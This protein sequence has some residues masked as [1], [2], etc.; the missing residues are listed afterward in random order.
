MTV[1]ASVVAG[2]L[3]WADAT[4]AQPCIHFEGRT[5]TYNDVR[6]TAVHWAAAFAA[7]GITPGERVALFLDNCPDFLAAYLGISLAG[8]VVVLVN[9]Q[10][11]QVELR[12][13]LADSGTRL[14]ITDAA[15]HAELDRVRADLPDLTGI[16][17]AEEANAFLAA[18]DPAFTP[19]LPAGDDLAVLGYT[20]GTTGRAKGAMILHRNLA[21]NSA[22]IREAWEWTA[23]DH[24]LLT[25]PLFHTHGL[26]VGAHGTLTAGATMSLSRRFDA[27]AV[28]H[29]LQND[30][31]TLFFGVPTMF[32]M[33]LESPRFATTDFSSLRY[34]ISGG[35]PCPVPLIEAY[36]RRSL[37]FVQGYGLTEVGPNCFKL[38]LED[39]V[40]KAGS[41]GFPAL[42]S[43]A[44]IVD[45]DGN[46]VAR[47]EIGEL[48]LRGGHVCSGYWRNEA[49]TKAALCDNWFHT[50]DLARQ[51][52][53][54]YFY[55]AGRAKDMIISGG[56][57]IYPAEVEAVLHAHPAIANAALIGVPDA[58]WGE[59]P[60]AVVVLRHAA[61]PVEIIEFCAIRLAR[62]KL[63]KQILFVEEFPF[64]ASGKVL[65]QTL[66]E[67]VDKALLTASS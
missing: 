49:A 29:A 63:P 27:P 28:F 59:V 5:L 60:V 45:A 10:Y 37:S 12:H 42:H 53:E 18:G 25:L 16:V 46:D 43:A 33:M 4:P 41:I 66:K 52:E 54:N 30:P 35:A 57:N 55:I 58:K 31:V 67:Y 40:R 50:G 7:W 26:M 13:I 1:S 17:I 65:K 2:F 36:Q 24:L 39:A 48:C 15:H 11:R 47:G 61:T 56:E 8:G 64:S 6:I 21:A 22:A 3:A 62:Y 23:N 14:C 34:F 32:Q 44:R 51:D 9:T 19:R 20:S 38:G